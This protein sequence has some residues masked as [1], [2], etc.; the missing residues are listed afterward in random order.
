MRELNN[1][2]IRHRRIRILNTELEASTTRLRLLPVAGRNICTPSRSI[3]RT[4]ISR[5]PSSGAWEGPS[6]GHILKRDP[7]L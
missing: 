5:G 3:L 1:R 4:F 7:I 6:A 2:A